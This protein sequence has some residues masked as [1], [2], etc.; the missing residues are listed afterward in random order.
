[1]LRQWRGVNETIASLLLGYIAIAL[2]KHLVEG[3]LRDPASLNKPVHAA[4]ARGAADAAASAGMRGALG[5]GVRPRGL[6]VLQPCGL[7]ATTHGFA[8]RVV[9]GNGRAAAAGRACRPGGSSSPPARWA[10]PRPGWPAASRWRPC[11]PG[12]RLADRGAAA[13]PASS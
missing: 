1:V 4:A 8:V 6:R 10:A 11:A 12:Q 13:T 3:P 2:F 9:G 7:R 5:P